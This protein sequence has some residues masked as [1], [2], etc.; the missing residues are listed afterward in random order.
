MPSPASTSAA[1]EHVEHVVA[2]AAVEEVLGAVAVE[3]PVVAPAAVQ[4]VRARAGRDDIGAAPAGD[5]ATAV[6]RVQDVGAFVA[7]EL[8]AA[9]SRRVTFSNP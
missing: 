6:A 2:R 7:A 4:R 1:A 9:R 3:E 8:V 5:A